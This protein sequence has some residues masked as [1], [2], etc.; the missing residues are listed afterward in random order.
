MCL[1]CNLRTPS[2]RP[3]CVTGLAPLPLVWLLEDLGTPRGAAL[4]MTPAEATA[5]LGAAARDRW[6]ARAL[7]APAHV[8]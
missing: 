5:A 2:E 1:Y 8:Y 4:T 6:L 3:P 7:E